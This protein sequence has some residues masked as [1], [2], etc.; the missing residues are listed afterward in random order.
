[1]TL[2]M[3]PTEWDARCDVD[4]CGVHVFVKAATHEGAVAKLS[5]TYGWRTD[6]GKLICR[7]HAENADG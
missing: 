2:V 7:G 3:V 1:M 5:G 4:G 6:D